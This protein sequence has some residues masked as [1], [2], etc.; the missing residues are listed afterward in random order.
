MRASSIG[1]GFRVAVLL[2][3]VAAS[4]AGQ[5]TTD[6]RTINRD[7][8]AWEGV[9]VSV[10]GWLVADGVR[11]QLWIDFDEPRLTYG[12]NWSLRLPLT[13]AG[14]FP[15]SLTALTGAQ[16][17]VTG[18]VSVVYDQFPATTPDPV[19]SV[20]VE[21]LT[22]LA[23]PEP[24]PSLGAPR[25]AAPS[26]SPPPC[27]PCRFALLIAVADRADYWNDLVDK[28]DYKTTTGRACP[29]GVVVLHGPGGSP[30]PAKIPNG[31]L[32]P[33]GDLTSGGLFAATRANVQAA[34]DY[35]AA[36]MDVLGC[37]SPDFQFHSSGHGGGYHTDGTTNGKAQALGW[38]HG[39]LDLDGDEPERIDEND[40]RIRVTIGG[41]FDIDL[42]G[43]DDLGMSGAGFLY[44]DRD[45]DGF[46]ET[47]V[48]VDANLDGVVDNRDVGWTAP[49]LNRNGV[50]DAI[51][52]DEVLVLQDAVLVD[53]EL[54]E[55]IETLQSLTNLTK[56]NTRVESAQCFSE[57]FTADQRLVAADTA[58]ACREGQLSWSRP[59]TDGYNFY[60][61]PFIDSLRAGRSWQE[62]H[63]AA[64]KEVAETHVQQS[65][66][67][68]ANARFREGKTVIRGIWR[69]ATGTSIEFTGNT[70]VEAD[71]IVV[72]PDAALLAD[73]RRA[74]WLRLVALQNGNNDYFDVFGRLALRVSD[75]LELRSLRSALRLFGPVRLDARDRLTL[76]ARAA[77]LFLTP[78]AGS[79][80][81][82]TSGN[83]ATIR[84]TG[85]NG[86]IRVERTTVASRS[87]L[88]TTRANT[89]VVGPKMLAL[90]D[91]TVLTTD[92]ERTGRT[93]VSASDVVL[94]AR[95]PIFVRGPVVL[96]SGRNVRIQTARDS[97]AACFSTGTVLEALARNGSPGRVYVSGIRGGATDDG[98]TIVRGTLYG[99]IM[100]PKPCPF[101]M[102]P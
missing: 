94:D 1:V 5:V 68:S 10:E 90:K 52:F 29:D 24:M 9:G 56:A 81:L 48:G 51:A 47:F 70:L 18:I 101:P 11:T 30:D 32:S 14:G 100:G 35:F 44:F 46:F 39:A 62:A 95:G 38:A 2:L 96:D 91:G 97:D 8:A 77:D 63:E 19:G 87:V 82:L 93:D 57:G 98:T 71:G 4:A 55:Y 25:A 72:E 73:P 3:T 20:A 92:P 53:D 27:D 15:P 74:R 16:V 76:D 66:W 33:D 75:D 49:D 54:H 21:S 45:G 61:R 43:V 85:N 89:S 84:A 64:L 67:Y 23:P 79:V 40:F 12:L 88:V 65:G 13:D 50:V 37:Q 31:T 80:G 69:I 6:I 78:I 59:G 22:V 7:P 99:T 83:V 26:A 36:R 60:E 28:Y 41:R 17:R 34:F 42:D 58:A 102:L 86:S